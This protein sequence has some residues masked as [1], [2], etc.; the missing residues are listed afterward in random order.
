MIEKTSL[1]SNQDTAANPLENVWVQANAGTGKT[2]VLIQRLLRILFRSNDIT[3]TGILCLTYTNIAVAEMRN[4]ILAGLS[5]WAKASDED[6]AILLDG[7]VQQMPVTKDDIKKARSI[8]YT[9]IDNPDILKIKTIILKNILL[10]N[11]V[12]HIG[13]CQIIWENQY[14]GNNIFQNQ[15]KLNWQNK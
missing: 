4:R 9:Y 5:S 3:K 2:K 13:K 6:L 8:F 11:M 14:T 15:N 10:Q 7:I 1:T 12:F